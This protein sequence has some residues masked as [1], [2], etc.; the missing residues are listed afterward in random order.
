MRAI[1]YLINDQLMKNHYPNKF[2]KVKQKN[3][4]YKCQYNVNY[5]NASLIY[6]F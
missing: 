3:L 2:R 5:S 6:I 1:L 4:N